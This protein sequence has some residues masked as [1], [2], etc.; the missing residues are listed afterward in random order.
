[1]TTVRAGSGSAAAQGVWW[2][3]GVADW[4]ETQER[5]VT[6]LYTDV[7]DRTRAGAGTRL[8][9]IGCG[10]G[11]FCRLAADRGAAVTGL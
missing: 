7:L 8:L 3:A 6:A 11:L 10:A 2:A 5:Q 9:D 1:M 4:A